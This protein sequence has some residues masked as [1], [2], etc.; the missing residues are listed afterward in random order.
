MD[1]Q[2]Q[3]CVHA[4]MCMLVHVCMSASVHVY[5]ITSCVYT[6]VHIHMDVPPPRVCVIHNTVWSRYN[7]DGKPQSLTSHEGGHIYRPTLTGLDSQ[8]PLNVRLFCPLSS[9]QTDFQ[10]FSSIFLI[11]FYDN[12][13]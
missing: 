13:L 9:T 10:G 6:C 1:M 8:F 5:V 12:L 4:F 11:I 2:E 3:V 7:G